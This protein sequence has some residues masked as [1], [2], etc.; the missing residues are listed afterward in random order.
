MSAHK[1]LKLI[2]K[3]DNELYQ[4]LANFILSYPDYEN[5]SAE[6]IAADSYTSLAT[7]T[8]FA[9]KMGY[10]GFRE[11]KFELLKKK[12]S[13]KRHELREI[14]EYIEEVQTGLANVG[15]TIDK[16]KIIIAANLI[17]NAN[18]TNIFAYGGT[19]LSCHDFY[20]KLRRLKLPISNE[21][22][23]HYKM[24]QAKNTLK[25]DI[26]LGVSY[27]GD[28]HEVLDLLK[29]SHANGAKTIL[30]TS[31]LDVDSNYIDL[32][33]YMPKSDLSNRTSSLASRIVVL[34]ILDMIY[35]EILTTK[36]RRYAELLANN[37]VL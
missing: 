18:I 3:A 20:Y 6:I 12:Q 27:S 7:I 29:V 32:V 24:V 17:K 14:D 1:K 28:T 16:Q 21:T 19:S 4:G 9:K 31:K 2:Q 15:T 22:D 30:I 25:G 10:N 11:F 5:L 13:L 33:I 34:I 35:L 8:R 37:S 36:K 23:T 26:A